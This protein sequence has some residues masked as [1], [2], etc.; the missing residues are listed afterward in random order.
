V[1]G[2]NSCRIYGSTG[3]LIMLLASAMVSQ[4]ASLL[5]PLVLFVVGIV[6]AGIVP[7][8]Q[9]T[10]ARA[11][12]AELAAHGASWILV[13][14]YAAIWIPRTKKVLQDFGIET[15]SF[16]MLM[17]QIADL[18][19]DPLAVMVVMTIVLAV[20]AAV[21]SRLSRSEDPR[22]RNR[23]SVG[24]TLVPLLLMLGFGFGVLVPLYKLIATLD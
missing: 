3:E 20:D 24:M 2:G 7:L 13:F 19:A 1:L 15:S 14:L 8:R 18:L 17:I 6:V 10:R 22:S 16:S 12:A 4:I 23:F 9:R 5:I 11:I 21:Y